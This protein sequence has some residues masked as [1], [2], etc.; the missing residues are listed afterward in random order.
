MSKTPLLQPK[1]RIRVLLVEDSQVQLTMMERLLNSSP[2]IEVVGTALNGVEALKLL[3]VITPD[4]IC[5][6][7]HMPLMNGLEFTSKALE[8]HPYPI[9]VLSISVQPEQTANIF[10]MLSAGAIDILAKPKFTEGMISAEMGAILIEKIKVLSGV[11]PIVAVKK[12]S[13]PTAFTSAKYESISPAIF[14]IGSSTGGVQALTAI[15]TKLPEKFPA[16]IVCVQHISTGFLDGMIEWLQPLTPLKLEIAQE[17]QVPKAG[18]AYFAPDE[19]Q[20]VIDSNGVFTLYSLDTDSYNCSSIS[21]TFISAALKYKTKAVGILLSGMGRSGV[22]GLKTIFKSGGFT[23]AQDK[24]SSIL[25]GMPKA[26]IEEGVVDVVLPS[27]EIASFM[28]SFC[29]IQ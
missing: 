9:L 3:L 28:K 17:G 20:L 14:V 23:M 5:T 12:S 21:Q 19:K 4:V 6:D 15:L 2:D 16:P 13:K 18:Y 22:E 25:F 24:S 11:V 8:I 1:K 29:K 27:Q 26:A 10:K 7:Y